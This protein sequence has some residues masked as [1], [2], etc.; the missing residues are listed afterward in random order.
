[1]TYELLCGN[2]IETLKTLPDSS[3]DCC[4]TSPPYYGLR[5]YGVEQQIGREATPAE[6]VDRLVGVFSEVKR[7]LK[8]TGTLW[9]NLGDSYAHDGKWGGETGGKQAYLDDNN[10]RRIGREKRATGMK[11]KDL[12]G[13]PWRVAFALQE[14][15]WWLRSDVVW[16]KSNCMPESVQDRPT[17][18]HEYIFLLTKGARYYYD[19]EAIKE[20]I[21]SSTAARYQ[22]VWNGK[23]DDGAKMVTGPAWRKAK[24]G[25]PMGEAFTG[26]RWPP[27]GGVKHAENGENP[28]YSGDRPLAGDLRNVRD[29]WTMPTMPYSGAHFAVFPPQLPA[30]CIK[31]GSSAQGVCAACG[32]PWERVIEVGERERHKSEPQSVASPCGDRADRSKHAPAPV[33][34]ERSW[35]PTCTCDNKG[36]EPASVLDPF[37]GSGTTLAVA[38]S[39]G[40]RSIGIELN[41]AYVE[42]ARQRLVSTQPGLI[43]G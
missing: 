3:I 7:V 31:A 36:V 29:V 10:R 13:I 8:P 35:Q 40:R 33:R 11:P 32:A 28:T 20:P 39:L 1:M 27:I 12:L 5:D 17:R 24:S 30:R 22:Y 37:A 26:R 34:V 18:S 15:G 25:V 4:V 42:L 19:A 43:D 6:Y 16:A 2:A 21:T 23:V 41:P 9:V 38:L 14:D